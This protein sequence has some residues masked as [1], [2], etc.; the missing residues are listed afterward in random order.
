MVASASP[1]ILVVEDDFEEFDPRLH[2][3]AILWLEDFGKFGQTE[4]EAELKDVLTALA[5]VAREGQDVFG[6]V[7]SVS[8]ERAAK[9]PA[10]ARARVWE[11]LR[12][13]AVDASAVI[14]RGKE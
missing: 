10:A 14:E 13:A 11:N 2:R 9:C 4:R 6:F 7:E 8:A 1:F 3:F 5:R 12:G